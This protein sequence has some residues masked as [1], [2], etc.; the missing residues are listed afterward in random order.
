MTVSKYERGLLVPNLWF[1]LALEE[2]G[3]RL[4]RQRRK[5]ERAKERL[6]RAP[7]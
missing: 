6:K 7:K 1:W 4:K 5:E 3:R 2:L